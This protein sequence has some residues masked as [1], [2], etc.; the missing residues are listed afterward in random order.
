MTKSA[1]L[2]MNIALEC[3]TNAYAQC[4]FYIKA[5]GGKVQLIHE[6]YGKWNVDASYTLTDEEIGKINGEGLN[7]FILHRASVPN[8][9]EIWMEDGEGGVK[10]VMAYTVASLS[11]IYTQRLVYQSGSLTFDAKV[12]VYTYTGKYD[13]VMASL[14]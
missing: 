1:S 4:G 6:V 2:R 3:W 7:L 5:D 12:T 14:L 8:Q 10:Q 9:L 13:E 11:N